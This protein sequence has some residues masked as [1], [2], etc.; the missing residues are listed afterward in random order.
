MRNDIQSGVIQCQTYLV[1]IKHLLTTCAWKST[2][3]CMNSSST[4]LAP[5]MQ[6]LAEICMH[7]GLNSNE[8]PRISTEDGKNLLIQ[9]IFN[10]G[11][12]RSQTNKRGCMPGIDI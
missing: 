10:F 7:L 2:N 9:S 5:Q 1:I 4:I 8:D 6:L 12:R 11:E 3:V